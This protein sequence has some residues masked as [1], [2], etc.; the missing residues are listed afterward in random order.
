[1]V[2]YRKRGRYRYRP[3]RSYRYAR[4]SYP[5]RR[6]R[7]TRRRGYIRRYRYAQGRKTARPYLCKATTLGHKG[8]ISFPKTL[9]TKLKYFDTRFTLETGSAIIDKAVFRGNNIY[10][11]D[12]SGAFSVSAHEEYI[13][14]QVYNYYT[15]V[16]SSI[17]IFCTSDY[18]AD[19][20]R[21]SLSILPSI[22]P[23]DPT[24]AYQ[25]VSQ[26]ARF[27][28]G[29]TKLVPHSNYPR[30]KQRPWSMKNYMETRRM[31]PGS[32][33]MDD[34]FVNQMAHSTGPDRDWYWI[35]VLLR[36]NA[37]TTVNIKYDVHITYYVF[38]SGK[39]NAVV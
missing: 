22:D 26:I 34:S 30:D 11:P 32:N 14:R 7:T 4:R 6:A 36:N 39:I 12:Y 2:R 17:K 33:P 27:K 25:E 15:V 28:G 16:A 1:M 18:T 9:W 13:W 23:T 10:D 31:Y 8:E 20:D 19:H 21:P 29:R 37:A 3:R 24:A 35:I 38:F 5:G